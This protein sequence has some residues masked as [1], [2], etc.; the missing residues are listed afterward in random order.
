MTTPNKAFEFYLQG[1]KEH[2]HM[3][4]RRNLLAQDMFKAAIQED[5]KFARAYGHLAYTRLIA[6]L[7]GWDPS[8]K[9]PKGLREMADR[10]VAIDAD[11]YDNLWSQAG[12]HFYTAK[13]EPKRA[14]SLKACIG[15]FDEALAIARSKG[16]AIE[17]NLDGLQVDKADA[18]FFIADSR[19]AVDQ[20]IRIINGAI[21]R[22]DDKHPRRFLWSLGWA[23]YERAFFTERRTDLLQSLEA[24]LSI[25][26]P[27]GAVLKNLIATYAALGWLKAAK[28]VVGMD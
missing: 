12:V 2:S 1:F 22:I 14:T 23:Q 7:N 15:L 8:P 18:Q 5:R 19:D 28:R 6:W 10:A 24:L 17:H 26:N 25:A 21:S 16:N 20:A 27:D 9:P 3:T 11:D 13:F 4:R